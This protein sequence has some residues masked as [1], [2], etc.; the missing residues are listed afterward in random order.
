VSC[1]GPAIVA[2]NQF[3]V[4]LYDIHVTDLLEFGKRQLILGNDQDDGQESIII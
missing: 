3:D 4:I 1:G 2:L